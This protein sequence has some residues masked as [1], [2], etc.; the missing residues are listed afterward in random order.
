M[1]THLK[2]IYKINRW[3]RATAAT[4]SV[5]PR[6]PP[7]RLSRSCW[8][9]C[10]RRWRRR[11]RGRGPGAGGRWLGRRVSCLVCYGFVVLGLLC[12]G[13]LHVVFTY[14]LQ[15]RPPTC[16]GG[17]GSRRARF[18]GCGSRCDDLYTYYCINNCPAW[19]HVSLYIYTHATRLYIC[20]NQTP[21]QQSSPPE[22]ITK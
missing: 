10:G 15:Q 6:L 16:G 2:C 9:R 7:P 13:S 21:H 14:I 12:V 1:C 18:G 8:R 5:L 17:S 20:T 4:G 19:D 22:P 3:T 11:R